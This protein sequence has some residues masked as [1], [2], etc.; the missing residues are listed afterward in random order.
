MKQPE[1]W[2]RSPD[3]PGLLAST[4]RP[5]GW[6]TGVLTAR[7]VAREPE[8]R[9]KVPVICVGNL[10]LGGTGKTPVV[11]ALVE[12]LLAMGLRPQILSRG[13]GGRI[14]EPTLV[15]PNKHRAVD[16]G[17]EPLLLAAF[18][19]VWVGK[20]RSMT[21]RAAEE[22]GADILIMDDGFQNPALAK[23]LSLLVVD[24]ARGFGNGLCFPAGPLREDV[25]R[26]LARADL[27]ILL[28]HTGKHGLPPELASAPCPII[29]ASL[30]PLQTGMSW[31][32]LKVLAFA[33]IGHPQKFF[34]TLKS[35]GAELAET[36]A[37]DD[38][39]PISAGL[40]TRLLRQARSM[41]AQLV[42]TEKDA[43]R[44]PDAMRREVLALPV[45]LQFADPPVLVDKLSEVMSRK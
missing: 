24:Q 21:A 45:R 38:H 23:D 36:I 14:T 5:M 11:I 35:L 37:L 41:N 1:F 40:A 20:D 8:Y 34:D 19:S 32:G 29:R 9:A 31:D 27:V 30:K 42:T 15:D 18:T 4:L 13:Y 10:H 6:L 7:R 3:H 22:N 28:E 12:Q 26:G 44:L 25:E 16:V 33:G 2:Y 17:D 39:Q 43:V